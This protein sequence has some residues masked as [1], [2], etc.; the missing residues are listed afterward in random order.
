[1][2]AQQPERVYFTKMVVLH[3]G[4][5]ILNAYRASEADRPNSS[6]LMRL[7]NGVWSKWIE[8]EDLVYAMDKR[9][10]ASLELA[11][12][13]CVLGR[14]GTFFESIQSMTVN[15]TKLDI[16]GAGY[17]M[18]MRIID[19]TIFVVGFQNIVYCLQ[20][21]R[22]RRLDSGIFR[23]FSGTIDSFLTAVD[24][25]HNSDVYAVGMAGSILHWDGSRWSQLDSPTNVTLTNVLCTSSKRVCIG[26]GG[27][28]VL[29]G[30]KERGWH[31]LTERSVMRGVVED[32]AEFEGSLYF[33]TQ[34]GLYSM[35]DTRLHRV[36][37]E[38]IDCVGALD[39]ACDALWA[40]GDNLVWKYTNG[41]WSYQSAPEI[42]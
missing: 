36:E 14:Q 33:G 16:R 2:S 12:S 38:G 42:N 34:Q 17:L 35:A 25:F 29:L 15:Q 5:V 37:K 30:D 22:W 40:A 23:P 21:G 32:I 18:G 24:G 4:T 9:Q 27:G 41:K 31:D 26:G 13:L 1:M 20:A 39:V 8:L 11:E 3:D 7:R 19:D 10:P 28:V 6:L